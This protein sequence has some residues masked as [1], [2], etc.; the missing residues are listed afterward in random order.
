MLPDDA[1]SRYRIMDKGKQ[2]R[3]RNDENMTMTV[4]HSTPETRNTAIMSLRQNRTAYAEANDFSFKGEEA[5]LS[6]AEIEGI[7]EG[8]G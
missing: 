7:L 3:P 6:E 4:G 5:D 2:D 1:Q 8:D